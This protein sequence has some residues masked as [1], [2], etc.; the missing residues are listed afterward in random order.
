VGATT[1]IRWLV[2]AAF[3]FGT[4]ALAAV[5]AHITVDVLGDHLLVHD[6]YD[7]LAHGSRQK[8]S[9]VAALAA[10]ASFIALSRGALRELR[11]ERN[12]LRAI[13][14]GAIPRP[15]ILSIALLATG[16]LLAMGAMEAFDTGLAGIPIDDPADLLGGSPLL[17]LGVVALVTPAL[18]FAARAFAV[19]L[20]RSR[21]IVTIVAAFVRL[22]QLAAP[23]PEL[24][25]ARAPRRLAARRSILS[26][27]AGKRGPPAFLRPTTIS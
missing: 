22:A 21:A 9:L 26:R 25:L 8:F 24:Q 19:A 20:L 27:R 18:A 5:L 3:I 7:G 4:I 15:S 2:A 12:A 11:G 23:P 17:A 16:T 10:L 14:L 6:T 1:R 13:L